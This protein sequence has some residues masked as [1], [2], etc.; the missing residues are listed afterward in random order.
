MQASQNMTP[1]SKAL[2]A[3]VVEGLAE[4]AGFLEWY[5]K[6]TTICLSEPELRCFLSQAWN[7]AVGFPEV[8]VGSQDATVPSHLAFHFHFSLVLILAIPLPLC[9]WIWNSRLLTDT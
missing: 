6:L 9:G 2:H 3:K 8:K 7:R 5:S 1:P 4:S